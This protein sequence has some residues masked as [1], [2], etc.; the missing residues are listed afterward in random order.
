MSQIVENVKQINKM[1]EYVQKYLQQHSKEVEEINIKP[2]GFEEGNIKFEIIFNPNN[3]ELK[4]A[5]LVL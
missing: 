4:K 5:Q 1:V 2:L 3:P